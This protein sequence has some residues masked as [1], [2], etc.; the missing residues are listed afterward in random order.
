MN[1]RIESIDGPRSAAVALHRVPTGNPQADEILGGGFPVNSINVVM[2]H[3]GTGKTIFVEELVFHNAADDR[4]I[5]YFTTMSEPLAKVVRYLQQFPFFDENK[6]GVQ[7]IYEDIG[8]ELAAG[9]IDALVPR[10]K[11]SVESHGPKIIVID[12]FKAVHDLSSST[13]ERRAS[14]AIQP[15]RSQRTSTSRSRSTA[16]R[17]CLSTS[18]PPPG[19]RSR[20]TSPATARRSTTR[21]W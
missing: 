2:G 6:I 20:S 8:G 11:E 1:H 18:R 5:L 21:R 15:S 10:I 19:A 14:A 3:P 17:R 4:P 9:G 12:S 16:G 13:A 7:V